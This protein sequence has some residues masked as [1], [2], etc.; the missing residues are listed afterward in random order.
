MFPEPVKL[1]TKTHLNLNVCYSIITNR[2]SIYFRT[3]FIYC[4]NKNCPL[5]MYVYNSHNVN[6]APNFL[7]SK[8]NLFRAIFSHGKI[9]YRSIE[10]DCISYVIQ[11]CMCVCM[12]VCMYVYINLYCVHKII[13]EVQFA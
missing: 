7:V 3:L 11:F 2:K 9:I 10:I 8:T 4:S 6:V 13:T 5:T 12:Y 1:K